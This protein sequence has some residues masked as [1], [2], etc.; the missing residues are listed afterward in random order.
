[1]KQALSRSEYLRR[2]HDQ[3]FRNEIVNLSINTDV[4][5]LVDVN[6]ALENVTLA[7]VVLVVSV[8]IHP[9]VAELPFDHPHQHYPQQPHVSTATIDN[10]T[11]VI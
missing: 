5:A 9:R 4:L 6:Q 10:A 11:I 2:S 8:R 3:E 7:L 1:M